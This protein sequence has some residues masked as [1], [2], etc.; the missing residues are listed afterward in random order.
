MGLRVQLVYRLFR[1]CQQSYA[2][3]AIAISEVK[4]VT[5]HARKEMLLQLRLLWSN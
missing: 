2:F 4:H 1:S 5:S 3:T